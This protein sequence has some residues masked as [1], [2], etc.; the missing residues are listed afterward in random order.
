M[1]PD[2]PSRPVDMA[3]FPG[4][5]VNGDARGVQGVSNPAHSVC[6]HSVEPVRILRAAPR[7]DRNI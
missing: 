7:G 5:V 2:N 4:H 3:A 1:S 6:P